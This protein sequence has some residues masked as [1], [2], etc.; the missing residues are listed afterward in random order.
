MLSRVFLALGLIFAFPGV[1]SAGSDLSF[2]V[3]LDDR[4]VG[5]HSF[6]FVN[7]E[8]GIEVVSSMNMEVKVLFVP[9]FKYEHNAR[10]IWRG[11]CLAEIS[12]E[13]SVQGSAFLLEGRE[14]AEGFSVEVVQDQR[15]PVSTGTGGCVASYA[16]WD[17]ARLQG[18]TLVNA[19]TGQL[20]DGQVI[21]LGSTPLPQVARSARQFALKTEDA[22]IDL[23][24]DND[25]QWLALETEAGGKRLQYLNEAV[26]D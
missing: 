18:R 11:A 24:Y 23:W 25:G 14:T 19:Q 4:A 8:E 7:Q 1:A 15:Q 12:A 17:L 10:E 16:Y 26:F 9:V 21:P 2:R 22:D 6:Q 5:R 3:W 13:T 20:S